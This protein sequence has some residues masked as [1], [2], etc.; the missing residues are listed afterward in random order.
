MSQVALQVLGLVSVDVFILI[1]WTVLDRPMVVSYEY[2]QRN[3]EEALIFYKCSSGIDSPF[4]QVI[5]PYCID[6]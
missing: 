4:E 6:S 1:L 5:M 3:V 2:S